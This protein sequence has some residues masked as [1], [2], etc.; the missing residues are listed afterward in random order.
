MLP[1]A[2]R[3]ISSN[4]N[5]SSFQSKASCCRHFGPHG[6]DCL[7]SGSQKGKCKQGFCDP[8]K[9]RHNCRI[10]AFMQSSYLN[11]DM[12]LFLKF[13]TD[14]TTGRPV[15]CSGLNRPQWLAN[16]M[17]V[18]YALHGCPLNDAM[19]ESGLK[20]HE[21]VKNFANDNQVWINEF[22]PIFH[23]MQENG[24]A[25]G[26]LSAA[27]NNWQGLVCNNRNCKPL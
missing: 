20:M 7:N 15:G 12:G 18:N 17:R 5:M 9:D 8:R 13:R 19:D 25:P 14:E 22:V 11:A 26:T 16:R 21:I 6:L 27:P 3:A 1:C 2:R 24:Y 10:P 23:K 4:F